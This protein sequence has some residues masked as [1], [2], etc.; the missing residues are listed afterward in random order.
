MDFAGLTWS[1]VLATLSWIAKFLYFRHGTGLERNNLGLFIVNLLLHRQGRYVSTVTCLSAQSHRSEPCGL[2][3]LLCH[4]AQSYCLNSWQQPPA[5]PFQT[6]GA[7]ASAGP[8]S[9][10]WLPWPLPRVV[11]VYSCTCRLDEPSAEQA[12]S[13]IRPWTVLGRKTWQIKAL[14]DLFIRPQRF[15][16]KQSSKLHKICP[17]IKWIIRWK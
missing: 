9:V 5:R 16:M 1:S 14:W 6:S 15:L 17:S 10:C 4:L 13:L 8:S 3:R 7:A 11:S 12:T 2:G